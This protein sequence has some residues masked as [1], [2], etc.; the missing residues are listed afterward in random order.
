MA[1]FALVLTALFVATTLLPAGY[2]AAEEEA[3]HDPPPRREVEGRV[4]L[5]T[6]LTVRPFTPRTLD[7]ITH[8]HLGEVTPGAQFTLKAASRPAVAA[9]CVAVCSPDFDVLFYGETS[10]DGFEHVAG[11]FNQA[12]DEAGKVPMAS[13][14]AFVFLRGPNTPP[15][16]FGSRFVYQE[17]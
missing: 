12:G 4:M 10:S 14:F 17:R 9:P 11:R 15:D 2:V 6:L 7:G 1:R 13:K 5:P 8:F 3:P 16:A